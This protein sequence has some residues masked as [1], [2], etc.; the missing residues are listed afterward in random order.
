MIVATSV[1]DQSRFGELIDRAQRELIEM[2]RRAPPV[3]DVVSEHD[4]RELGDVRRRRE[5]AVRWYSSD[6]RA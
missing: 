1:E 3:A 6:R 2:T 4:L 5:E